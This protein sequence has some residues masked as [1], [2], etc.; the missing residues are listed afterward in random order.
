MEASDFEMFK[1]RKANV[2]MQELELKNLE[3]QKK[4][5]KRE[6]LELEEK[7]K[8]ADDN[9]DELKFEYL[10]T[11]ISQPKRQKTIIKTSLPITKIPLV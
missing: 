4:L 6:T 3:R 9:D 11:K 10:A 8:R 2:T 1:N 7:K 5:D